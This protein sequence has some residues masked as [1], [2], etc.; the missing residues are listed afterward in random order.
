MDW[1]D[2]RSSTSIESK[3]REKYETNQIKQNIDG[4]LD[5]RGIARRSDRA[6][7]NNHNN[8]G[9]CNGY[10]NNP[11]DDYQHYGQYCHLHARLGLLHE[12]LQEHRTA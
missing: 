4:Q 1:E 12:D 6:D 10:E 2:R 3:Q 11:A 5:L 7:D 8:D 9:S